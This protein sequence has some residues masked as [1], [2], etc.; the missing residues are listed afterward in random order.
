MILRRSFREAPASGRF[1]PKP[2]KVV[3]VSGVDEALKMKGIEKIFISV[4]SGDILKP[5]TSNMGKA[6]HI[7]AWGDTRAEAI[8]NC[9]A[10]MK[11]I[12]IETEEI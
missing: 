2:G 11:A 5:V 9:E 12:R 7:V 1:N 3:K 4:S 6:G 8:E 10:A